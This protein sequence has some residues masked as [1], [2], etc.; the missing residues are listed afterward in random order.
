MGQQE[1]DT[2][3]RMTWGS[4]LP[5]TPEVMQVSPLALRQATLHRVKM[6]GPAFLC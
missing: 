4:C 3:T 1:S 6:T 2:A 5:T